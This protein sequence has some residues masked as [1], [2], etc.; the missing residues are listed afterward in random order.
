MEWAGYDESWASWVHRVSLLADVPALVAAYDAA[1]SAFQARRAAPTRATKDRQLPPP[2]PPA[3]L[4]LCTLAGV[5]G[6]WV[7][8]GASWLL[9]YVL[10][11][12]QL[13]HG[14]GSTSLCVLRVA[15]TV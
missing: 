2:P 11:T 8:A 3:A 15:V 4:C 5:A 9:L 7:A 12:G 10:R 6:A 14:P 1:L 13:V